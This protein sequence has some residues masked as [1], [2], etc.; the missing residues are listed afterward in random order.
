M[1]LHSPVLPLHTQ[2]ATSSSCGC[3]Y[4]SW[5][6]CTSGV[7]GIHA[8]ITGQVWSSDLVRIRTA[9]SAVPSSGLCSCCFER[10]LLAHRSLRPRGWQPWTFRNKLTSPPVAGLFG[11]SLGPAYSADRQRQLLQNRPATGTCGWPGSEQQRQRGRNCELGISVL[12]VLQLRA[13]QTPCSVPD[14]VLICSAHS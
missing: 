13:L 6:A 4:R 10:R 1:C 12:A 8:R 14:L 11:S 5:S 7:A 9:L 3:E 2:L